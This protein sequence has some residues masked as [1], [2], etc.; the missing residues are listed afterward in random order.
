MEHVI[1]KIIEY[2]GEKFLVTEITE[3]FSC[4]RCFFEFGRRCPLGSVTPYTRKEK[5]EWLNTF[6]NCRWG[7]R[8]KKSACFINISENPQLKLF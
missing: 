5:H 6:G 8:D 4:G 7:R 3:S 1:G 2:N